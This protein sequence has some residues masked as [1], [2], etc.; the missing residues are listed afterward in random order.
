MQTISLTRRASGYTL[1]ELL[2][3]STI[4]ALLA[5]GML[6][7]IGAMRKAAAASEHHANS[8]LIDP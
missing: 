3:G 7:T 8:V 1:P 2:I 5:A 6:T 4:C